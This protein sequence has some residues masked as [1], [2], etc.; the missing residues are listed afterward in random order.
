MWKKVENGE[1][2]RPIEVDDASSRVYVYVRRNIERVDETEDRSAHYVWDEL[3]VPKDVW[4]IWEQTETNADAIEEIAGISAESADMVEVLSQAV[5][6][7]A[8][9]VGGE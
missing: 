4:E 1:D 5:E 9:I 2:M 3:T 8:S 6:E 7:L